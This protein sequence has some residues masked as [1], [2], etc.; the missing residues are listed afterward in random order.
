MPQHSIILFD[1]VCNLCN[2]AVQFIIRRDYT[3]HFLFAS[4][5]S[6]IGKKILAENNLSSNEMSSF[7]LFENGKV[8]DRSTAVLKVARKLKSSWRFLYIFIVVPKFIRDG[9]YRIISKN[10]Y[11]WFGK[12]K[13]CMIPAPGLKAKFLN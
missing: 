9:I 2:A 12:K 6:E 7:I 3:N 5:Q 8:Y 4:L 1:G 11:Q 13:E 10:R